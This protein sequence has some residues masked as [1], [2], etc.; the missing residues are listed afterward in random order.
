M[1]GAVKGVVPGTGRELGARARAMGSHSE[2]VKYDR[3]AGILRGNDR[4]TYRG[5]STRKSSDSYPFKPKMASLP[6]NIPFVTSGA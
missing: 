5:S 4:F 3:F 6:G 1:K 2:N